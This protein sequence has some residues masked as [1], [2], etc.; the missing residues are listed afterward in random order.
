MVTRELRFEF[1]A[2]WARFVKAVDEERI[3]SAERSLIALLGQ[4][5]LDGQ[6][7]L[8]VGCG[9]GLSSL[10][11]RRLGA[12]VTSFDV[13]SQS[14]T[15]AHALRDRYFPNDQAWTIKRGSILDAAFLRVL[16]T[17]DAVYSWGVLHHTGQMWEALKNAAE[18][19]SPGGRLVV[20]VYNDQGR[21]TRVWRRVKRAY[22]S[23]PKPLRFIVLW[24]AA[25]WIWGPAT[26]RDLFVMRPFSTWQRYRLTRGMSPWRDVV[27][28]VGGYPFEVARP[29]EVF[30]YC[31]SMGFCLTRLATCAGGFGC[32]EFAFQRKRPPTK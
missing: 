5:R 28:W 9:S 26:V 24:P 32:N 22:N 18:L 31:L 4:D 19:V 14:V 2:N 23:L 6:T 3:V 7:F 11:A 27:D 12:I 13:D 25:A 10:A 15:C 8:D 21:A 17:F 29:E 1:G 20:A 30:D 16:P